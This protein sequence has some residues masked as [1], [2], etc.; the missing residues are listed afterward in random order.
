LRIGYEAAA[1]LECMMA[2]GK[3]PTEPILIPPLEIKLRRST[4]ML[5]I[6]DYSLVAGSHY[7]REHLFDAITVNDI[8]RAAGMSRRVFERRFT[9]QVGR[10]P[11]EEILR[12]RLE[13]VKGLL[14]ETNC[15]LRQIATRTGFKHSEYLHT[16][17]KQ[18]IGTTPGK[19]R[20]ETRLKTPSLS[21][22]QQQ[23]MEANGAKH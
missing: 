16:L 6:N 3:P 15:T 5:A 22:R 23:T 14:S 10:A 19:F 13:C 2:G 1:L 9:A 11:R 4:D 18:K 8:A 7:M 12:L 20:Q 21:L 17:F